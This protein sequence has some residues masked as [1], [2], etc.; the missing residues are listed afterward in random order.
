MFKLLT[1]PTQFTKGKT[2]DTLCEITKRY[3]IN[4]SKTDRHL[5][6]II[7]TNKSLPET[8]QWKIRTNNHLVLHQ[9]ITIDILSSKSKDY[10]AIDDYITNILLCKDKKK[11][12]N[13]LIMCF[14]TKRVCDDLIKMFLTF[15]G[16]HRLIL[17]NIQEKTQLE[18]H[19]SLDEV[20]ANL[21]VS[22]KFIRKVKPYIDNKSVSG[23][24]FITATAINLFWKMLEENNITKLLNMNHNN[25]D[26]FE[27]ELENYRQF[28]DHNIICYDNPTD[29]PLSYIKDIYRNNFLNKER[30]IVFAPGHLYT[31]TEGVGS[32]MEI[33]KYFNDLNYCVL[34][35]NGKVKQFNYPDKS[36]ITLDDFKVKFNIRGELRDILRE[37]NR[38][39]PNMNIAIT[40]YWVIERGI[41]F[42]T[43]GFN[44]T[45]VILSNY[46][47]SSI[48]KLI[49]LAGRST[50]GKKYVNKMNIICTLDIKNTVISFN[51][52]LQRICSINPE[53][54]NR[55][56][57]E[58]S[59]NTIPIKV[60]FKDLSLRQQ[61]MNLIENRNK[62]YKLNVHRLIKTGLNNRKIIMIDNNNLKKFNINER[63]LKTIRTYKL[64][65][66]ITARRFKNFNQHH[67][68]LKTMSQ[69]G[70]NENYNIDLCK[71]KYEHDGYVNEI[72]I[73][74]ITYKYAI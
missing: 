53:S 1:K 26:D 30:N 69:S 10:N 45:H 66:N 60:I 48:N 38:L 12:P 67:E 61:I 63:S 44:F 55:T 4:S 51:D 71:D 35:M 19:I 15:G 28:K 9:D 47:L 64:N 70:T 42:N 36:F 27:A 40:G 16:I 73:G 6:D 31:N 18:F 21:G 39:H 74:W 33:C 41:T 72:D 57:F 17:P 8:E 62:G 20:D 34:V 59:D 13:I 29:N 37:W 23:V 24:L 25:T 58:K 2:Q 5:I 14:H 3:L 54:F 32:H 65:D 7:V 46:H 43:D 68:T 49:Q 56:D 22:K 50:G 11:L 52:N